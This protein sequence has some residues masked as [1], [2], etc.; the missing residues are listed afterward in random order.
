MMPV[1]FYLAAGSFLCLIGVGVKHFYEKHKLKKIMEQTFRRQREM[2]AS[3]QI[4]RKRKQVPG[5][6][7]ESR[8][9]SIVRR[10]SLDNAMLLDDHAARFQQFY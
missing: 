8:R 7:I 10:K 2:P 3:F 9:S 5:I 4:V 1:A 6:L